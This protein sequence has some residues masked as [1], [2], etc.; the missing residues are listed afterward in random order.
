MRFVKWQLFALNLLNDRNF[1]ILYSLFEKII[2][3]RKEDCDYNL[4]SCI[5]LL[6]FFPAAVY[7]PHFSVI[8]DKTMSFFVETGQGIA[9][10]LRKFK[11]YLLCASLADLQFVVGH[12]SF[13]YVPAMV[14]KQSASL[15]YED[16]IEP[17][18]GKLIERVDDGVV[19]RGVFALLSDFDYHFDVVSPALY[20]RMLESVIGLIPPNMLQ[21]IT[22]FLREVVAQSEIPLACTFGTVLVK[23]KLV[24]P[25]V[26]LFR[27]LLRVI[28][29]SNCY[30]ENREMLLRPVIG[31]LSVVSPSLLE[32]LLELVYDGLRD[33]S[34]CGRE[35]VVSLLIEMLFA[36]CEQPAIVAHLV[37]LATFL[38]ERQE[39]QL[40]SHMFGALGDKVP[41][42]I[43][44]LK[45]FVI[46]SLR[47]NMGQYG[48]WEN[49]YVFF[50]DVVRHMSVDEAIALLAFLAEDEGRFRYTTQDHQDEWRVAAKIFI[51]FE[52]FREQLLETFPLKKRP[53][54]D[55][56]YVTRALD[57][58]FCKRMLNAPI[59][60]D[61]TPGRDDQADDEGEGD[62]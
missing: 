54:S 24:R 23:H 27:P 19:Q 60:H 5:K 18:I 37:R 45:E 6:G 22:R 62:G 30:N 61:W 52:D 43:G 34:N 46:R 33:S 10:A 9:T 11:R 36:G 3:V 2:E 21:K 59:V 4:F 7:A 42:R 25:E 48:G 31:Y 55:A 40:L 56:Y 57:A 28:E 26:S 49:G 16:V 8:Y 14:A 20:G 44:P 38:A 29:N 47:T 51:C 17:L 1:S 58:I 15:F 39:N 53:N 41:E 50:G 12:Q 32:Q 35:N 13:R